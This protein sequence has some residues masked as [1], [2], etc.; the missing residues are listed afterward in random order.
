MAQPHPLHAGESPPWAHPPPLLQ[1]NFVLRVYAKD[2]PPNLRAAFTEF[3][4]SGLP[5]Y[6]KMLQTP[7]A[8]GVA[9]T[10]LEDY[11]PVG[12]YTTAR[13][14]AA[15][16]FSTQNGKQPFRQMQHLLPQRRI[17][18]WTKDEI[19]AVSN[20]LRKLYWDHMK[21]MQQPYCWDS[22][23][24]YF[25]A[26]DLYQYGA[27]N[28]WNVINH[29]FDENK[30]IYMD[31]TKEFAVH[32]GHWADEWLANQENKQRLLQWDESQGPLLP[33]LT[34]ADWREIG[35]IQ[36]DAMP[37]IANALKHRRGILIS[38]GSL[39]QNAKPNHLVSSY[40]NNN[41]ENW[42][43]GQTVFTPTGLPSPPEARSHHCS[44]TSKN[45]DAPVIVH[46]A[47]AGPVI[48]HGSCKTT[49]ASKPLSTVNRIASSPT[50]RVPP[51]IR[52]KSTEPIPRYT[53]PLPVESSWEPTATA[54]TAASG[55][56]DNGNGLG[57]DEYEN[58]DALTPTKVRRPGR[59]NPRSAKG[60]PKTIVTTSLPSSA[61]MG[62]SELATTSDSTANAQATLEPLKENQIARPSK[63]ND[64]EPSAGKSKEQ[65]KGQR[66]NRPTARSTTSDSTG[67]HCPVKGQSLVQSQRP[68]SGFRANISAISNSDQHLVAR[69]TH[70][71]G[72]AVQ[73]AYSTLQSLDV[74]TGLDYRPQSLQPS[75]ASQKGFTGSRGRDNSTSSRFDRFESNEGQWPHQYRAEN[76]HPLPSTPNRGGY[77][78]GG[79]RRGNRRAS[80]NQRNVTAP[81]VQH[82][83][84]L[85]FANKKRDG[86]PWNNPTWRRQGS[87]LTPVTCQNVQSA[88]G[89]NEYVPCT[90]EM[91]NRRN[92][93]VHVKVEGHRN[94]PTVDLQTRIKFGLSDRYGFV[95]DV[96]PVASKDPGNFIALFRNEQSVVE[97]LTI[98]GGSMP[99]RGL[100]ITISPA[101]RSKWIHSHRASGREGV[102]Q[103]VVHP[104]G[105]PAFP[106]HPTNPPMTMAGLGVFAASHA[107][108]HALPNTIDPATASIQMMPQEY[109]ASTYLHQ[110]TPAGMSA[111]V[112]HPFPEQPLGGK[113]TALHPP[114]FLYH[115]KRTI[116]SPFDGI[117]RPVSSLE[118]LQSKPRAEEALDDIQDAERDGSTSPHSNGSKG[119]GV[120]ARVSLP[121]TPPKVAQNS[122]DP[123][124]THTSSQSSGPDL[125]ED[126]K[127][128]QHSCPPIANGIRTQPTTGVVPRNKAHPESEITKDQADH[129]RVPSIFTEDEIKER[130][131]AWAKI[132]MPLNSHKPKLPLAPKVGSANPKDASLRLHKG[133]K[134]ELSTNG[135]DVSSPTQV[136]TFTPESGSVYEPSPEKSSG[137]LASR[138]EQEVSSAI[139]SN[140]E[141]E[142]ARE[143]SLQGSESTTHQPQS[144]HAEP[145]MTGEAMLKSKTSKQ[146][147][148][149]APKEPRRGDGISRD[150]TLSTPTKM[151][152][153]KA[154]SKRCEPSAQVPLLDHKAQAPTNPQ[155]QGKGKKSNK[156]KK[157][158]RQASNLQGNLLEPP[159]CLPKPDACSISG[160]RTAPS[161]AA[162]CLE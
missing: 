21:S 121:N 51:E 30:T 66:P 133:D 94:D 15:A 41:L 117:A 140:Q 71:T 157:K 150:S 105:A 152:T 1:P 95:D 56:Q 40:M 29:L 85:A 87:N 115:E 53:L 65:K 47:A 93:S 120:K 27:L 77:Q 128:Q 84:D 70:L 125:V 122:Q 92:R 58:F 5:N 91:C 49:V 159:P 72:P 112:R 113:Q 81:A 101:L 100:S 18:L 26:F 17:H 12:F 160:E 60:G 108:P 136:V 107:A 143:G 124:I 114:R 6:Y 48:A 8:E 97:A 3:Y 78:R 123:V 151:T 63:N 10:Y 23:W 79:L 50:L 2:Q 9:Q 59:N 141:T 153:D 16:I 4:P 38:G 96:Y 20:S 82:Q 62:F 147:Q 35:N 111:F 42:L 54:E 130:Q 145:P 148:I 22:L 156:K 116:S 142:E 37:L 126:D 106:P 32:I 155:P 13:P 99:D 55:L 139:P 90:C 61:V 103:P 138:H 86:G 69:P 75:H 127:N 137:Q 74:P 158:S 118:T 162:A 67:P 64:A 25:D 31:L 89:I 34:D 131:Q 109:G 149:A 98:G 88:L 135:S 104:S 132:S 73:G 80:I 119:S 19:Q 57:D 154:P 110:F 68:G 7:G 43:A 46:N 83:P 39:T 45:A 146:T 24:T 44:P 144:S 52:S 102:I 11:L 76:F 33:L 36:D 161:S 28:L 14:H 134:L 129:V